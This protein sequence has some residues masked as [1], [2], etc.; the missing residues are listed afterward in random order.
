MI[1]QLVS[2]VTCVENLSCIPTTSPLDVFKAFDA[3][4]G[5]PWTL[6]ILALVLGIIEIAI[7]TRTKSLGML[8]VLGI[9]TAATFASLITSPY[10]AS[11]YHMIVYVVIFAFASIV[12][13]MILKLV[14]E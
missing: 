7:Y 4:Y 5:A 2:L 12:V 1:P 13:M 11:Q 10:V 3:T 9:Y 8:A 6:I 14:K